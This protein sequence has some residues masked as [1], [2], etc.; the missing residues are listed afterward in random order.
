[1]K[2]LIAF[3]LVA[4]LFVTPFCASAQNDT[5]THVSEAEPQIEQSNEDETAEKPSASVASAANGVTT[6][7][8][9]AVTVN[10]LG[11]WAWNSALPNTPLD[12][13]IYFN[14]EDGTTYKQIA[15]TAGNYRSDLAEAGYGNGYHSFAYP[16]SWL[17]YTPRQYTIKAYGLDHVTNPQLSGCPKY[18]TVEAPVITVEKFDYE[19]IGGWAWKEDAPNDPIQVHTY[20]RRLN[21]ET[22]DMRIVHA[23]L[24][25]QDLLNTGKGN[26]YHA[27]HEL[28][29]YNAY[30]HEILNVE[31][32][33]V[34]GSGYNASVFSQNIDNRKEMYLMGQNN[35]IDSDPNRRIDFST[36]MDDELLQ[37]CRNIGTSRVIRTNNFDYTDVIN[38]IRNS[39]FC[40]INAHGQR[41]YI[42]LVKNGEYC[43]L[44]M[45]DLQDYSSDYF[46]DTKC[47]TLLACLTGQYGE[48]NED[49]LACEFMRRGVKCVVAF[50]TEIQYHPITVNGQTVVDDNYSLGLWGKTYTQKL[51]E[52]KTVRQAVQ[53]ANQAVFLASDET[54][55]EGYDSVCVLGNGGLVIKH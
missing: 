45:Y 22:V 28:I 50:K 52:G 53:N 17:T 37:N 32:Y 34:D 1:M 18:Y 41:D 12:V 23:N 33:L 2:K 6:G 10:L 16:M 13:H 24:F 51:S 20:T 4:C 29:N 9:D 35:T 39:S 40:L 36:W 54:S 3:I 44:N 46:S 21:G 43:Y 7:W 55:Y 38:G 14:R 8:L 11:G 30:P 42:Q 27:F 19:G 5:S 26:G 49:N 47:V 31:M 48:N 25:R 15:V